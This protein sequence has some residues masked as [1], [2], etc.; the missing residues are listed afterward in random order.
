M[1]SDG[2]RVSIY[3]KKW[4]KWLQFEVSDVVGEDAAGAEIRSIRVDTTGRYVFVT[5]IVDGREITHVIAH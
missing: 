3:T 4:G 2:Q 1:A 5:C